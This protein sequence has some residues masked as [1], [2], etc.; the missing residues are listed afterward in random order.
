MVDIMTATAADVQ[1][2]ILVWLTANGGSVS[3][4]SHN[5]IV[6]VFGRYT[7]RAHDRLVRNVSVLTKKGYITRGAG[8]SIGITA[9]GTAY[10]VGKTN[11]ES[12]Y[13]WIFRTATM[14][15]LNKNLDVVGA[16]W[17]PFA[18]NGSNVYFRQLVE[19]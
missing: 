6:G 4:Y 10:I 9:S 11:D 19:K 8:G 7:S 1:D 3:Y 2:E 17:E 14:T 5:F 13:K 15:A 18:V 12:D 16:D